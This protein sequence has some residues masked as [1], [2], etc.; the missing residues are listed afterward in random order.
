MYCT[1]RNMELSDGIISY[2]KRS[3][4]S[5]RCDKDGH[6]VT[7]RGTGVETEW[8]LEPFSQAGL[9]F[10]SAFF[11]RPKQLLLHFRT[12]VDKSGNNASSSFADVHFGVWGWRGH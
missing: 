1:N 8:P 10:F 6:Q 11:L 2:S 3:S 5:C 4:E 9:V 12:D 7:G